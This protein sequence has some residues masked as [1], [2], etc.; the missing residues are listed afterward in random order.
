MAAALGIGRFAYTPLLPDMVAAFGWNFTRAGDIASANYLGYVL[1]A[2][3]APSV[4]NSRFLRVWVAA[5]LMASVATTALGF[6][7]TEYVG[8]FVLRFAAGVASAFC[9]V[10][11]T[12]QIL[13]NLSTDA[14]VR[15]GNV[16]FAGVGIGIL[17]CLTVVAAPAGVGEQW[18]R[19]GAAA[20]VLMAVAWVCFSTSTWKQASS[21][22]ELSS[23]AVA[24]PALWRIVTGY[25]L[26]GY[27]YVVSAT[28]VVAMAEQ[29]ELPQAVDTD[30]VW[31]CVGA[32]LV[33]S[34]YLWQWV[35]NRSGLITT[36]CVAYFVEA[37]GTLL[38]AFAGFAGATESFLLLVLGC[39][40]LGGTFAAITA[41]G[42]SAAHAVAPNRVARAVSM[43]TAAFALGQLIGPAA[44]GRMADY[45]GDFVVASVVA[46]GVLL[47]SGSLLLTRNS[48]PHR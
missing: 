2:L 18:A 29:T 32:S 16:H 38:V 1:G 20:A 47:I 21:P 40:L 14:V 37:A 31:W 39:V 11:V 4:A 13:Q 27:G 7:T 12:T 42:I 44:S 35:A 45:F 25:G 19:L 43:M 15:F 24:G 26:F 6:N 36:L 46:A 48:V 9:L 33:P 8:W 28:F 23:V 22:G 17:L 3:I 41:L 10:L 34:V 30:I 5:S